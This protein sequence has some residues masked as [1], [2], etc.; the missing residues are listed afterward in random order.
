VEP[1]A[2][3]EARSFVTFEIYFAHRTPERW[4]ESEFL[5][6]G[7]AWIARSIERRSPTEM[8]C[9]NRRILM[10]DRPTK[11]PCPSMVEAVPQMLQAIIAGSGVSPAIAQKLSQLASRMRQVWGEVVTISTD[12]TLRQIMVGRPSD[13]RSLVTF[14]FLLKNGIGPYEAEL[15]RAQSAG[16]G[17]TVCYELTN[18]NTF[19]IYSVT[20]EGN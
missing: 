6:Q 9:S 5:N 20:V 13:I 15:V 1:D 14:S 3:G 12:A 7:D 4:S 16:L 18:Q 10:P 8:S 11:Q 17:V 2:L 19:V